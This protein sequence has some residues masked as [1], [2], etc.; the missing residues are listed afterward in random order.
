MPILQFYWSFILQSF[1][2]EDQIK[3]IR[4]AMDYEL[5]QPRFNLLFAQDAKTNPSYVSPL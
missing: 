3:K 4:T 2:N 5:K 1:L